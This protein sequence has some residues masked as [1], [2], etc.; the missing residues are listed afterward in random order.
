MRRFAAL[1][2]PKG[3]LDPD[4]QR[5]FEKGL[6][7]AGLKLCFTSDRAWVACAQDA[8]IQLD[9]Q[10]IILG[11]LFRR[12]GVRALREVGAD[13]A[14]RIAA[15]HGTRLI[16]H[17]WGPYVAIL[18][19]PSGGVIEIVRA[20]LGELP[21][22]VYQTAGATVIASDIDLL[23]AC[24]GLRPAVAW[25]EVAQHLLVRD[26][27]RAETCLQGVR[28][29]QGGQRLT[30]GPTASAT[31]ALWTPWSCVHPRIDDPDEAAQRVRDSA[32][33]CIAARASQQ[34]RILLLLSGGLD[35]SVV[36]ACL[37]DAGAA[38]DALTLVTR[39]KTGD[40]RSYARLVCEQLGTTLIEAQ[41]DVSRVDVARSGARHLPR[42]TVRLFVQ[43]SKRL[44]E[45]ASVGAGYGA[46]YTGG[47]GDNVFCSL[48]S[49]GPAADRLLVA[50]P[51]RAFL[52][53]VGD[54]SQLAPASLWAVASDAVRRAWLG[55]PALRHVP[56]ATFLSRQALASAEPAREHP[57]LDLPEG[58]LP[59]KAM[60]VRLLAFAQSFVEATDPQDALPSVAP[61][62]SQP[63]VETCLAVPS[64][65]WF[66][67]GRNRI[68]ARRAF[69]SDLPAAIVQRRSKGTP[70]SFVAAIFETHRSTIRT[71]LA[72][73][74]LAANGIIDL[75][76]ALRILD[77]P[78]P[79]QGAGFRRVLE[80][81]DAETWARAWSGR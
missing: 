31:E 6:R 48:Q 18:V 7:G 73:G 67:N 56:D 81:V 44:I 17:H 68:V 34:Q 19:P 40:E 64:W 53:T 77:D 21:C 37:A 9:G 52:R 80:L 16:A 47:G 8:P 58:A 12:D 4:L 78:R 23:V 45:A 54:I 65:L 35:S 39:E 46:V 38:F 76:A 75:A 79:A 32:R 43:E 57:W 55:K 29:L 11:A 1:L 36:A 69:A 24:G 3:R 66:E 50:G 30:L 74:M 60:H 14:A 28:E 27:R 22:Y 71:M 49:S 25:E 15:T 20:P 51:G 26:T 10:G 70:D 72:D 5:G 41:R 42:P 59:G 33:A 13:E 62:L 63:L 61:L 2:H